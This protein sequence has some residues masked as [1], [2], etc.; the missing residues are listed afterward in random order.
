MESVAVEFREHR[1]RPESHLLG[2][3]DDP[4]RDLSAIGDEEGVH[5]RYERRSEARNLRREA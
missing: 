1:D 5:R 3:T 2:G 4:D